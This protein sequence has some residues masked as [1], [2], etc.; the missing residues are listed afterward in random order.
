MST[1]R[2]RVSPS[3]I[4]MV[5]RCGIQT[6]FYLEG[7]REPPGF[8]AL[9]GRAVD[10]AVFEGLRRKALGSPLPSLEE[11]KDLA[12]TALD[13]EVGGSGEILLSEEE[14]KA[15]MG[16]TTGA[17]RDRSV[18]MA[19]YH[20]LHLSPLV[21]VALDWKTGAPRVQHAFEIEWDAESGPLLLTG[22]TDADE[23]DGGVLDL[24]TA[25]RRKP[26]AWAATSPQLSGY[27]LKRHLLDGYQRVP[28][29]LQIVI[30]RRSSSVAELVDGQSLA[31]ITQQI[32]ESERGAED[33]Q[34]YL[35]RAEAAAKVIRTGAFMPARP[36]DWWCSKKFCGYFNR[37]PFAARPRSVAIQ[38]PEGITPED[39]QPKTE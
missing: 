37:C 33:F 31:G 6:Q 5:S 28:V 2:I 24:K 21:N 13:H 29:R 3:K 9:V 23:E 39:L 19:L 25:G 18:R 36:D 11:T 10:S 4:D 30:D 16:R 17:A 26:D 12:S 14:Q 1:E 15:G 20:R 34:A 27:A 32:Q 38:A 8:A 7:R 22:R 35:L